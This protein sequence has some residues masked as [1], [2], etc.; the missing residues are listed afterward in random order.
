MHF[1]AQSQESMVIAEKTHETR[2]FA[3]GSSL[4]L[5]CPGSD[6]ATNLAPFPEDAH[7]QKC[8]STQGSNL[9]FV[10]VACRKSQVATSELPICSPWAKHQLL[11]GQF[12]PIS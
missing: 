12:V 11:D 6:V 8:Q 3:S 9:A 1:S 4:P 7:V 10:H 2:S 5:T